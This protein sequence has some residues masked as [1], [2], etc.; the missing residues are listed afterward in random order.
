M[1][2]LRLGTS[3]F[4]A[5][6][7]YFRFDPERV[8]I[9]VDDNERGKTTMLAAITAALY[10]LG[11][12]RRSH[13]LMT[14]LERWRPWDG[15]AYD[16]EIEVEAAGT[17]Y[18]ISRDFDRSTVAVR[19]GAGRDV[20]AEFREGKDQYPVG[21]KLLGL[22][23]DEFERCAFVRQGDLYQVV[24]ENEKER[25]EVTLRSRLEAAADS[26]L[27]DSRASDA[28]RAIDAA[29]RRYTCAELEFTGTADNA[30]QRLAAKE[31]LLE[32]EQK[33]L[34]HDYARIERPL[35]ELAELTEREQQTRTKL[36][37][38]ESA[39][40]ARMAGEARAQLDEDRRRKDE[41]EALR[42][43]AEQ[44]AACADVPPD[45]EGQLRETFAKLEAAEAKL[46]G[47]EKSRG[48]ELQRRR[49]RL[50][51]ELKSLR[52]FDAGTGADADR[53]VTL[54]G[55]LRRMV[56]DDARLRDEVFLLREA[57]ASGGHDGDRLQWLGHRLGAL[58]DAQQSLLRRQ[59]ER[60][61]EFQTEVAALEN[62]RTTSSEILREI[63][64]RRSALSMP[65]WF[66]LALGIAGI[67]AGSVV[68]ALQGLQMLSTTFFLAGA[69]VLGTGVALSTMGRQHRGDE[70]EE[71]VDDLAEAQR[72]LGQLRQ[73]RTENDH[74][75]ESLSR[76][77]GYR[78]HVELIK[79]WGELERLRSESS[80]A[81]QAQHQLASLESRRQRALDEARG[82][83]AR[84]GES[85][86]TAE[87]L[88]NVA[89]QL[90]RVDEMRRQLASLDRDTPWMEDERIADEAAVVGFRERARTIV[91][92]VGLTYEPARSREDLLRDLLER[93]RGSQ[94]LATLVDELIPAAEKRLLSAAQVEELESRATLAEEGDGPEDTRNAAE[95]ETQGRA[96]RET[97]E[98]LQRRRSD[99]R[100]EVEETARR[101]NV[102]SAEIAIEL[103]RVR[104]AAERARRF[105]EAA[106]L[107]A[108]TI[109]SV[110][111]ETHR[112]W[113]EFLNQRVGEL[114]F[115]VGTRIEHVRFG[116]DLDFSVQVP[117]TK[118]LPRGKADPQL[119]CAARDQ[120]YLAVRLAIS[121]YL[122]RA[123]DPLPLLLDDVFA[124]SDDERARAGMRTLIE[125]FQNH[126][127]VLT[128]CHRQRYER[129]RELDPELYAGRVQFLDTRST[130]VR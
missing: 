19:D 53:C 20:A 28:L 65:G 66:L 90:R 13:R 38:I 58:S 39:R 73:Q 99:L 48:E 9:V 120:L 109:Q 36:D 43:E 93:T 119:S 89:G 15:H 121:E 40:R 33:T 62:Q 5:L 3:G 1:K 88:E 57:L 27:G 127:I 91:E 75:L 51:D 72:R 37:E 116:D 25:R 86:I 26:R 71:A 114:L 104:A 100:V 87:T 63:D 7:G 74:E 69:V 98:E 123:R 22:D 41:V 102:K 64:G 8:T 14:P 80:P 16:V 4:G 111:T 108:S 81:T 23:A 92:S 122:S 97:F 107:A 31:A 68:V 49:E 18:T 17:R 103:E 82:L 113:A 106:Q 52:P 112:R 125:R 124:T 24:P 96:L 83:L 128:T 11:D 46:A 56:E 118:P 67:L 54:A 77:L 76:E 12:D 95:E 47:L 126:Q 42:Q 60:A 30:I 101:Y 59:A 61:L 6:R 34:E 35:G 10:G 32:T 110:A 105:R 70:R 85:T 21:Q 44:L 29:L 45:A 78:D 117:G 84:F 50:E 55:E 129:L 115:G 79:E 94:R 130:I 2:L